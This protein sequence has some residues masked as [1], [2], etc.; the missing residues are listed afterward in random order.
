MGLGWVIQS[1]RR[2]VSDSY[3][4]VT[5]ENTFQQRAFSYSLPSISR[6]F[7]SLSGAQLSV[8][9]MKRIAKTSKTPSKPTFCC[10]IFLHIEYAVLVRAFTL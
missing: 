7:S 8:S 9:M 3:C 2:F 5:K 6:P 4:S 1:L 10:C